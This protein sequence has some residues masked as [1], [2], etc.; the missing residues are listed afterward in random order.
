MAKKFKISKLM[1][2]KNSAPTNPTSVKSAFNN[3]S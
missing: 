1:H 2:N 3:H